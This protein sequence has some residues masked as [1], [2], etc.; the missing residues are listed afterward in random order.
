MIS[1][2]APFCP[3]HVAFLVL[4]SL[5]PTCGPVAPQ[6]VDVSDLA[7]CNTVELQLQYNGYT[8][9]VNCGTNSLN[10]QGCLPGFYQPVK[11]SDP[12]GQRAAK[13]CPDGHWCP[14]GFKC[15]IPCVFGRYPSTKITSPF[16]MVSCFP[17][18]FFFNSFCACVPLV[19]V[20]L[21]NSLFSGCGYGCGYVCS[22]CVQS[23][24]VNATG[25]CTFPK[26]VAG[27]EAPSRIFETAQSSC[28]SETVTSVQSPL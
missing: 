19:V 2:V 4:V 22:L 12:E 23:S 9:E 15:T 26:K 10:M 3:L 5:F 7:L 18:F 14:S 8:D 17:Q 11:N 20:F 21:R 6:N 25:M 13:A 27:N 16:P 1:V 28:T 24:K